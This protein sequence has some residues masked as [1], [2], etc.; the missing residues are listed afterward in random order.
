ME[1][2]EGRALAE[3][4]RGRAYAPYSG[5]RVGCALQTEDGEW[6]TGC[7]VENAS[8][9]VTVCA[10]RVAVG[11]AVAAGHRRFRRLVLTTD[12]ETPAPP[13]GACRQ[14]LVEFSPELPVVSIGADGTVREWSMDELLPEVFRLHGRAAQD[15]PDGED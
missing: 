4:A 7:N 11:S 15:R 5:F 14:V 12:A 10:E 1:E 3:Q 9:P 2:I 8:F 6:F 13:C